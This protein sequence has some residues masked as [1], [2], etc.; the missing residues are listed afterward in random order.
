MGILVTFELSNDTL[1]MV[2]PT[3]Q[4]VEDERGH[5]SPN[6]VRLFKYFTNAFG[7]MIP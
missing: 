2:L 7:V 5:M 1:V 3:K 4:V 6:Y